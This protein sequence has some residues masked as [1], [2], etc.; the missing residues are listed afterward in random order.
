VRQLRARV[1]PSLFV[2]GHLYRLTQLPHVPYLPR[3]CQHS[4]RYF[5]AHTDPPLVPLAHIGYSG[6]PV[7]LILTSYRGGNSFNRAHC[8]DILADRVSAGVPHQD[9]EAER[10]NQ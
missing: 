9:H 5:P 8:R 4:V 1:R 3:L 6:W 2:A 10:D 7:E